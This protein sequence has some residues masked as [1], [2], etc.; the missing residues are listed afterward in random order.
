MPPVPGAEFI[1]LNLFNQ[2][3]H[4]RIEID[5]HLYFAIFD[6]IPDPA[7][8]KTCVPDRKLVR[9]IQSDPMRRSAFDHLHGLLDRS[10]LARRQKDVHMV[11][12]NYERM[13]LI[14]SSISAQQELL[15]DD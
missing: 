12:H 13:Q 4:H 14:K 2:L 5:V 9:V 11:W 10:L 3:R 6:G 8:V 15:K 7:V 1:F